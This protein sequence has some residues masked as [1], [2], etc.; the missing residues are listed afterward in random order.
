MNE[1]RSKQWRSHSFKLKEF[2]LNMFMI[3]VVGFLSLE[4]TTIKRRRESIISNVVI[5]NETIKL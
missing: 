3:F 5:F 1:P 2:I 4:K